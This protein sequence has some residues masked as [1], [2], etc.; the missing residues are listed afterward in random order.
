MKKIILM[1]MA[2]S[3]VISLSAC[4][5]DDKKEDE[6]T[7]ENKT[8]VETEAVSQEKE[9][10]KV[11]ESKYSKGDIITMGTYEQDNDLSNGKEPIEWI[12][13]DTDG[14]KTFVV[15]KYSLDEK[16]IDDSEKEEIS[17]EECSLRTWLND[18]FFNETFTEEEKDII[19]SRELENAT[20]KVF[21]LSV[22]EA[23][24]YFAN[25]EERKALATE[26]YKSICTYIN[27]NTGTTFWWLR[28]QG[29]NGG[30]CGVRTSGELNTR[31]AIA[32]SYAVRPAMWIEIE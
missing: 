20:D 21:L 4:G 2:V 25:S 1:M 12:V 7:S 15:S 31:G 10:E 16:P 32:I 30:A 18:E 6:T 8:A 5:G 13:L 22:D 29:E 14:N 3:V 9:A 27:T 19:L 17:W 28:T 24:K 11:T 23:E 26:Y